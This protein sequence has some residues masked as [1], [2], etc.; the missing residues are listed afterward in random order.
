MLL[1]KKRNAT[2]KPHISNNKLLK[3]SL[4]NSDEE[5]GTDEEEKDLESFLFG[6]FS[7]DILEDDRKVILNDGYEEEKEEKT[8]LLSFAISTK[9][10][11]DFH[12]ESDDSNEEVKFNLSF[13]L[14]LE[15]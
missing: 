3:A 13:Y 15:Y 7:K 14:V 8:E 12:V 2:S 11:V 9:P 1:T 6:D 4:E 5:I 10:S